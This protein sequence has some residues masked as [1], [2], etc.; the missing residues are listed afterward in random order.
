[1]NLVRKIVKILLQLSIVLAVLAS[2]ACRADEAGLCK[3]MCVEEKRTCRS[4]ALS[5]IDRDSESFTVWREK[6][7]MAREFGNGSVHT[8]Q[9]TG[10]AARNLQDRAMTR[11]AVCDDRYMACTKACATPQPPFKP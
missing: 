4:A 3:P 7:P 5:Q 9:P 1:M 8:N 6:N 2:A 10:P 11:K